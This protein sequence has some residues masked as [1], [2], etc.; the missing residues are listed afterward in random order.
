MIEALKILGMVTV[1]V[2]GGFC[3]GHDYGYEKAWNEIKDF[4]E[5]GK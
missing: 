3:L 5:K 2:V 4:M 1:A